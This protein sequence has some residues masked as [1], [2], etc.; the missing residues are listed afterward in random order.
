M[1]KTYNN[2]KIFLIFLQIG[3]V[4]CALS[5]SLS[6]LFLGL[7][8]VLFLFDR[9]RRSRFHITPLIIIILSFFGIYLLSFIWNY[10]KNENEM[11][12]F[13]A[14][15]N[16][17]FKDILLSFGF[18][19][20]SS[21][22]KSE[23]KKINLAI[24]TLLGILIITGFLSI[25]SIYRFSYLINSLFREVKTWQ[26]QHHYGNIAN[27]DIYLPIG[28]MNTHLTFGG[29]LLFFTPYMFFNLLDKWKE[30]IELKKKIV[31]SIGSLV[32]FIVVQ[33]NNARSS[34]VGS[35]FGILF[36]LI[37]IIF[38]NKKYNIKSVIKIVIIPITVC[39]FLLALLSFSPTIRKTILPLLGSEK[40]TDSGRTFIW[41]S[42]FSLI[43]KNPFLGI[44]PGNYPKE[45]DH[46]R[47]ERS[48]KNNEL[49]FF[50]EVTQRGHAHNDYFHIIA[51]SGF[52]NLFL[53]LG[54][55]YSISNKIIERAKQGKNN[56]LFFGL[57]G[58]FFA[59]LF[60]CYFQDDE[61]VIV[62]YYL[63]GVLF[64]PEEDNIEIVE[65][66]I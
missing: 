40:H 64:F 43:E 5:V 52:L 39:I 17:E 38:I 15:R 53:Y 61:V 55:F 37:V 66:I 29:L 63:L 2:Q 49:L 28:F 11:N 44:G 33:L 30:S 20:T 48:E 51:I 25:F 12:F 60:Q 27:I 19:L 65:K 16:S 3:I 41:D 50:Y 18:I 24:F 59:G 10:S 36:G 57:I 9:D 4:S 31:L 13:L 42:T 1:A 56:N 46:S 34:M 58:F 45:I 35:F 14:L 23:R 21:L 6:Q 47:R 8:F 54:I 7:S 22:D 32:F 62:F 26:Y